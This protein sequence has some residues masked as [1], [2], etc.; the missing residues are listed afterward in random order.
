MS[1]PQQIGIIADDP[2]QRHCLQHAIQVYGYGVLANCDPGRLEDLLARRGSEAHA[3]IVDLTDEERWSD[4]IDQ[5]LECSSAPILFGLGRAPNR[6][7]YEYPW[8][9]RRLF[10]KLRELVGAPRPLGESGEALGRLERQEPRQDLRVPPRI[11]AEAAPGRPAERVWI[12]GASLGG[13]AAVK[14]FL[15][16]LP[17]GLPVAFVYAQHIDANFVSVL[18]KVLGRHS[19]F[20]LREAVPGEPLRHGEVVIVPVDRELTLDAQGRIQILD[21]PWPGPY[22]P[23][24][25]QVMLNLSAHYGTRCHAILFSGMGNDGAIAA[26]TLHGRGSSIW[27]QSSETCAN[28]SMPDSVA[29]TGCASFTGS[30]EELAAHLV[31]TIEQEASAVR[32]QARP[33]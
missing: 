2:L 14:A 16:C 12:L 13:P 19:C 26:P 22:G 3:W 25:D 4:A 8:W 11:L 24:I 7:S 15:D 9:E 1:Q 30:P 6:A 29:A 28:S 33:S 17:E 32:Q 21:R 23:S 10:T 5:L 20:N 18:T 27:V 31:R